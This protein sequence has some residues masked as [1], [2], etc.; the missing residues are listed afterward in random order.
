MTLGRPIRETREVLVQ[1]AK[2]AMLL[3]EAEPMPNR[4]RIHIQAAERWLVLAQ[5]KS[6]PVVPELI[7]QIARPEVA[8]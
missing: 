4:A 6:K 7:D 1:R 5:R 3:A 8:A 2:A